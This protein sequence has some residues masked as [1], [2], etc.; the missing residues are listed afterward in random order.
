MGHISVKQS[1][2]ERENI[3]ATHG[4]EHKLARLD[5]NF[6]QHQEDALRRQERERKRVQQT[7]AG[8]QQI[9]PARGTLLAQPFSDFRSYQMA[10]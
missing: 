10:P 4:M 5:A 7:D 1:S 3:S 8:M 2:K 9:K 6:N